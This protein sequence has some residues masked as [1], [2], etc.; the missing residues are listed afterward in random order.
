MLDE[1]KTDLVKLAARLPAGERN[2]LGALAAE[3]AH[4]PTGR[5]AVILIVDPLESKT[6]IDSDE[7][8]TTL[9]IRRA[10]ALLGPE[11]DAGQDLLHRAMVRRT[12]QDTL[13]ADLQM[14]LDELD[15]GGDRR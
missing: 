2:G 10:E 9:R 5:F 6:I 14:E 12:G 7:T 11:F 1:L 13:P 4:N 3:I 15:G 8:T